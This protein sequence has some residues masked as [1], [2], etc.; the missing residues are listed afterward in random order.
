MQG[1]G[2]SSND[3][4]AERTLEPAFL[5]V[6]FFF[7]SWPEFGAHSPV[8]CAALG[9]PIISRPFTRSLQTSWFRRAKSTEAVTHF[10]DTFLPVSLMCVDLHVRT[11]RSTREPCLSVPGPTH[12]QKRALLWNINQGLPQGAIM[13]AKIKLAKATF[14]RFKLCKDKFFFEMPLWVLQIKL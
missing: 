2:Y 6:A 1:S 11:P 9:A 14:L 12:M 3:W 8:V 10:R 4:T 5:G 13:A 7:S